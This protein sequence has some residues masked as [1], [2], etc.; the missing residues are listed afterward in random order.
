MIQLIEA[1]DVKYIMSNID[2]INDRTKRHTEQIREIQ[3]RCKEVEK[4]WKKLKMKMG[5]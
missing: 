5:M 1:D 4:E 3:K 2:K